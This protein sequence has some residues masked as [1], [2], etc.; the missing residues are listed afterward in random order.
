MHC[1]EGRIPGD[2]DLQKVGIFVRVG[3]EPLRPAG[4]GTGVQDLNEHTRYRQGGVQRSCDGHEPN[5][6]GVPGAELIIPQVDDTKGPFAGDELVV[7]C[8][9]VRL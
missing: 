7:A 6:A 4:T 1:E 3:L 8:A 2:C 9:I 5:K